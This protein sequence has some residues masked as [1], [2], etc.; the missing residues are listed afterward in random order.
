M[1]DAYDLKIL[2]LWQRQGDI[3]PLEMGQAI[4]LSASQCSRRMQQLRKAGYLDGISAQLNAERVSIGVLAYVLVAMKTHNPEQASKFYAQ[5]KELDEVLECQ[6][7]TGTADVILKV[8]TRDLES[9]NRLL[10]SELLAAPEVGSAQSS[11]VLENIKSTSRLP[12]HF[13]ERRVRSS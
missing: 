13:A 7:L 9:F 5:M 8:A 12:L 6:T 11:I 3:G 1:L 10:T 4:N 2:D